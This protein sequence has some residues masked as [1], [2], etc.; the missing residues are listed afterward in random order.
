VAFKAQAVSLTDPSAEPVVK[1][2]TLADS[3]AATVLD[4]LCQ[5]QWE[6]DESLYSSAES[7]RTIVPFDERVVSLR[8][9][10]Q[11]QLSSR[12]TAWHIGSKELD[13]DT[14]TLA[15]NK[16]R[17]VKDRIEEPNTYASKLKGPVPGPSANP[18]GQL[19]FLK[20]SNNKVRR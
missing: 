17:S 8:Q 13:L 12:I 20:K 15:R 4:D 10:K 19:R 3:T 1:A 18:L 9:P 2:I 5:E 7:Q 14:W 6:S 11:P 16:K